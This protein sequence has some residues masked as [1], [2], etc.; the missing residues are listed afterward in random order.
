M[1]K[2]LL[3]IKIALFTAAFVVIN[4]GMYFFLSAT[5]PK[6]GVRADG[7][8]LAH[9]ESDSTAHGEQAHADT[10]H[11]KSDSTTAHAHIA[12]STKQTTSA[13]GETIHQAAE[14]M[15]AP[16]QTAQA[17]HV[18]TFVPDAES[19]T[20]K[21]VDTTSVETDPQQVAQAAAVGGD[22][23][24]TKLAKLLESMKPDEA[25]DIAS[26][27]T[28]DQ[29]VTLVMKMKDRAAGKMLAALPIEQAARVAE[30]MSQTASRSKGKK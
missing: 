23:E 22:K 1:F 4:V 15:K 14:A 2:K 9:L 24:M 7:K 20:E 8:G 26:H 6:A 16:E 27:L 11:A 3:L 18:E 5:Q 10:L 17:A 13:V 21:A 29:I 19:A 28:T 30:R 25:A 12:D